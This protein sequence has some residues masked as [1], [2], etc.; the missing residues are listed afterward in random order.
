MH[1]AFISA[2]LECNSC[3]AI[4]VISDILGV[5]W[6]FNKPGT[7]TD[8]NWTQRLDRPLAAY[9]DDPAMGPKIRFLSEEIVSTRRAP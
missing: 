3:W 4:F 6:Q 2:L 1:E 5:D 7:A 8:G 9:L